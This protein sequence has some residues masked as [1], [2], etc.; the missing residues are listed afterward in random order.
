M[1]VCIRVVL[2]LR[3]EYFGLCKFVVEFDPWMKVSTAKTATTTETSRHC[4][5]ILRNSIMVITRF[6][7]LLQTK[8]NQSSDSYRDVKLVL[9]GTTPES[10]V[11]TS[12]VIVLTTVNPKLVSAISMGAQS[13]MVSSILWHRR[14]LVQFL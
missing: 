11:G 6:L 4:F 12:N 2:L 7:G 1:P 3:L 5:R 8:R 9:D 13:L 14:S 10:I